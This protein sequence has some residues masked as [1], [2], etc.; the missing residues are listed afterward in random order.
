MKS[1]LTINYVVTTVVTLKIIFIV[2]T[3]NTYSVIKV[4][5]KLKGC[6]ELQKDLVIIKLSILFNIMTKKKKKVGL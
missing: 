6:H 2:T 1:F 3:P 5:E 4:T